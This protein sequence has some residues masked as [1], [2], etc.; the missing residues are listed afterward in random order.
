MP[1]L[2][3]IADLMDNQTHIMLRLLELAESQ[4]ET[5]KITSKLIDRIIFLETI[6]GKDITNG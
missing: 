4:N 2:P 3:T 6:A 1:E 5:L